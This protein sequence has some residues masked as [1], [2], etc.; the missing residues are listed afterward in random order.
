[1][2]EEAGVGDGGWRQES[3]QERKKEETNFEMKD[4]NSITESLEQSREEERGDKFEMKDFNAKTE[5]CFI[6]R[7]NVHKGRW[8]RS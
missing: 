7:V 6:K 3:N 1:M 2:T 5:S 8:Y 4:L